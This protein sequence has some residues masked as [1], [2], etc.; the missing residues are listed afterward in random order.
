MNKITKLT[1]LPDHING[2]FMMVPNPEPDSFFDKL[3]HN[4][5]SIDNTMDRVHL[6]ICNKCGKTKTVRTVIDF[7]DSEVLCYDCCEPIGE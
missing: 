7:L 3:K 2:I 6:G 1:N 5:K 4:T